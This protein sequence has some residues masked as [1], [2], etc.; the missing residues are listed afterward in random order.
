MATIYRLFDLDYNIFVIADNVVEVPA[1][2]HETFSKVMLDTL[3]PK[4]NLKVI[5]LE[6]ALQV[7]GQ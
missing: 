3:V 4:M 7:L 1:D 6:D 2:Q 5:S